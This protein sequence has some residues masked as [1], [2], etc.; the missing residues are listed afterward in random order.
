MILHVQLRPDR[1]IPVG[2][3]S[4]P[5]GALDVEGLVGV[6]EARVDDAAGE[7]DLRGMGGNVELLTDAG[8]FSV[9][10]EDRSAGDRFPGRHVNPGPG[11]SAGG[12]WF[13]ADSLR[14]AGLLGMGK[15]P[16]ACEQEY[17]KCQYEKS[18]RCRERTVTVRSHFLPRFRPDWVLAIV[19]SG[20]ARGEG[21]CG[22]ILAGTP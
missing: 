16:R 15:L 20:G 14:L 17:A 21:S 9:L 13:G 4:L 6:E 10:D 2:A 12:C 1:R 5:F 7:V 22:R 8:Y 11:E 19:P 18:A 3:P